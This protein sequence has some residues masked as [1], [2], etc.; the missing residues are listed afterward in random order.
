M[1]KDSDHTKDVPT[2]ASAK[3]VGQNYQYY[4]IRMSDDVPEEVHFFT[5]R[6][7]ENWQNGISLQRFRGYYR[8]RGPV[9]HDDRERLVM[10]PG[11]VYLRITDKDYRLLTG[12]LER[13]TIKAAG[14]SSIP[15]QDLEAD[16]VVEP[17]PTL[18]KVVEITQEAPRSWMDCVFGEYRLELAAIIY[19]ADA[20]HL[21]IKSPST[22][23][24]RKRVDAMIRALVDHPD[25]NHADALALAEY[26]TD[27]PK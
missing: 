9:E 2:S 12:Y 16:S 27:A 17:N 7:P 6:G 11:S 1:S 8:P 5:L 18:S 23:I 25:L 24:Q 10:V 15:F 4:R 3:N 19:M 26:E 20:E 21:I 14:I 22:P 13:T